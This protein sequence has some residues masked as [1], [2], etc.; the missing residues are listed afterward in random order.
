MLRVVDGVADRV[1]LPQDGSCLR[2]GVDGPD[3]SGKTVFADNLAAALRTRD[4]PVV[5]ISLDDFH[6]VRAIRYRRGRESPEGFWRDSYNYA[7]FRA[8]VLDAFGPNGSRRYRAACH[9]LATDAVL[10]PEPQLA[11]PGTVL[12][13]DGL[14]LHRDAL[15]AEWDLSVFLDVPFTTTA[16]RMALRDG[17]NPDPEHPAMRRYV[18]A[19]RIYFAAC[20]PQQRATVL[21]D[22][23]DFHRPRIIRGSQPAVGSPSR[24]PG[25]EG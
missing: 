20:A 23:T 16:R 18:E 9:D 8:D 2:V 6:N 12:V 1:P 25:R 24:P 3:G 5:R 10:T 4:R 22:N 11:P 15:A 19:Q 21:V 14:F 17:T 7:R 13:V